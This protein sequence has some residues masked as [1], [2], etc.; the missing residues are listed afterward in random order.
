MRIVPFL[1]GIM[2]AA[3]AAAQSDSVIVGG[4]GSGQTLIDPATGQ[5]R[6]VPALLEPWQNQTIRLR[7]PGH[8]R[9]HNKAAAPAATAVAPSAEPELAAAPPPPPKKKRVAAVTPPPPAPVQTPKPVAQ[10]PKP[11]AAPKT[12]IS[13]FGDVDLITGTGQQTQQA[14]PKS[15]IAAPPPKPAAAAPKPAVKTA[16]IE[17]PKVRTP[18]GN[19]KDSITFT[20]GASEPSGSAVASVRSLATS[21]SGA[22]GESGRV[23][24]MA[25]AGAKGEKTSDT[26]RLSL[27]R[28]LVVRQL[29]IDDGIPSERIDVFALGGADDD[30]ALDRVDVFVKS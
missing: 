20:A 17:K 15:A 22:I 10:A 7:P 12:S 11:A 21:L 19:R 1:I 13:G 18:T 23:Q 6:Y 28:A 9:V 8:H 4:D 2:L 27:K 26:R 14:A 16:S 3:P 5:A 25:Y 30:G 29:L 24:L